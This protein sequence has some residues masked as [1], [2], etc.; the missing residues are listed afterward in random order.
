MTAEEL[1][2]LYVKKGCPW[3][4]EAVQ[5]L[6]GHGVSYRLVEVSADQA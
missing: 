5:F 3:C 2:I 1:P 4:D 6:D